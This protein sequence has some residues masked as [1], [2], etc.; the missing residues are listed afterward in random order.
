[1][2]VDVCISTLNSE[3]TLEP[4]LKSVV[5]NIPYR[6]I[7]L[8]DGGSND[9]TIKIAE[10]YGCEIH[11]CFKGLTDS[12]R[13]SFRLCE[14]ELLVN[15]D[16]D[17]VLPSQ[18][19]DRCMKVFF[20]AKNRGVNVGGVWGVP[21][22]VDPLHKAYQTSMFRFKSPLKY[23]IPFLPDMIVKTELVR[24]FP[25]PDV[26]KGGSIAGEDYLIRDYV[27]SKGFEI[28][29]ALVYC[30]HYTNPPPITKAGW[31]GASERLYKKTS[32]VRMLRQNI[33]SIPQ[34]LFTS[35]VSRNPLVFPYWVR[36][37]FRGLK[38]YLDPYR[39]VNLKR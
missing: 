7:F 26:L 5:K 9:N 35:F 19:F 12:R 20:H 1:M 17:I 6:K 16:S 33:L 28:V 32:I 22:H 37:R 25:I 38:G 2:K 31:G 29:K 21:V 14:T 30:K 13:E 24:D 3:L 8:M 10:K 4:C 39:Y 36:F 27:R 15:I 18:W 34:G 11:Y 23:D